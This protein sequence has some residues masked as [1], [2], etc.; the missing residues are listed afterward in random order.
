MLFC[1]LQF[2]LFFAVVFTLYW[3]TPWQ[4][5][6]VWLLLGASYYFYASWNHWLALIICVS[7]VVD[8]LIARGM[9]ASK[10]T[11]WR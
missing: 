4:R 3:V 7:T 6:R 2:V 1:S 5:A 10:A 8:Y 9:D 11:I